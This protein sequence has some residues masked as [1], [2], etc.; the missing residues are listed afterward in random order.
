MSNVNYSLKN[1]GVRLIDAQEAWVFGKNGKLRLNPKYK[2]VGKLDVQM[3]NMIVSAS[4]KRKPSYQ[5]DTSELNRMAKNQV[6]DHF[7]DSNGKRNKKTVAY[8][9]QTKDKKQSKRSN[10]K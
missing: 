7:Y 1:K 2:I 10:K 3:P 9:G 6:I 5:G 8:F 4:N